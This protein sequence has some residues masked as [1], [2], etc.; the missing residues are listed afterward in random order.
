MSGR[1]LN[2][3]SFGVFGA[4][5]R[6]LLCTHQSPGLEPKCALLAPSAEAHRTCVDLASKAIEKPV[7]RDG[8]VFRVEELIGGVA[9]LLKWEVH[10]G[11]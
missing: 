11:I 1:G 10:D 6:P 5:A 4:T 2:E 3:L 8:N 9:C 7:T